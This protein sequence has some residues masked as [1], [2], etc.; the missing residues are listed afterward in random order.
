MLC[1]R[2]AGVWDEF[3]DLIQPIATHVPYMVSIGN[4]ERDY[5]NSQSFYSGHDSGGECGVPYM[6]RF[7]MPRAR[8]SVD[9]YGFDIGSAHIIVMSTEDDFT[10]GTVSSQYYYIQE[11]LLKVNRKKTPWLIFVGHRPMYVDSTNNDIPAGDQTVA[12][13]LR[14]YVEPLLMKSKV[15][16]ALWGH[17][18]SYQRTCPV[19]KEKCTPGAPI[20]AV[21]GMAGQG[22]SKNIELVTP[23]WIEYI[24]VEHY[25][26]SR[27]TTNA[28]TLVFEYVRDDDGK[29]H[30]SIVLQK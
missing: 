24:D 12:K 10:S 21:I 16:L 29:V 4:H 28:S 22:L 8:S 7:P 9:C 30:D 13:T 19:Y 17:H 18:H 26:Y 3:F 15:D 11:L 23:D 6:K 27:I 2:D 20:H 1:K 14:E 5:P 25:G